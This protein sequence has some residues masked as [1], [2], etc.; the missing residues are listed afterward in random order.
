[1]VLYS[2]QGTPQFLLFFTYLCLCWW[3]TTTCIHVNAENIHSLKPGDKLNATPTSV[4]CSKQGTYCMNFVESRDSETLGYLQMYVQRK[5]SWVVWIGNRD[6][7]VEIDSA[8]L[9]LDNS[10]VLKIESKN[11]SK[12][13]Y[14]S[15][16][17]FN[18]STTMV[19]TLLDTGNFVLQDIQPNGM[20]IMLWQSFDYPTDT[21]LPGM[22]LG[23]NHKTG[24]KWSLVSWLTHEIQTSGLFKLE[25]E[26]SRRQLIIKYKE[27]V[28]WKSKEIEKNNREYKIVS[29]ENEDSLALTDPNENL[30]I[31]TLLETGKLMSRGKNDI[32]RAD[33]CYGYKTD[34]GCQ[35]WGV[36]PNC[37]NHGD[38]F[39]YNAGYLRNEMLTDIGNASNNINDCQTICWS[40]CSCIGFKNSYGNGTGCTFIL[41]MESLNIASGGDD[42]FYILVKSAVHN[43]GM[44]QATTITH[45]L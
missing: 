19:A 33:L 43:K 7:P 21:L 15:P 18:K 31:W 34:D 2:E 40:N 41:S 23:V 22:K 30:T 29:D 24:H 44:Y 1:M 28:Y 39:Q 3:T 37:R 9:L 17:P 5:D 13:L 12:I 38:V 8:V 16:Q 36:M 10:G 6:Q 14:S 45:H 25:W 27:Q 20:K 11:D 26:P 4:M 42:Y 32:A 35:K